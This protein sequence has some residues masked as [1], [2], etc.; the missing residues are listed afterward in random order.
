MKALSWKKL[1]VDEQPWLKTRFGDHFCQISADTTLRLSSSVKDVA[2]VI[3]NGVVPEDIELLTKL[4]MRPPQGITD[5]DFVFGYK[6]SDE[7]VKGSLESDLALQTYVLAYP[8]EWAIVQKVLGIARQK[9]RHPCA[10]VIANQPI[11]TFIPLT[12]VGG[13]QTTQYTAGSVEAAGGLKMDFLVIN[14]LG[15]IRD[16]IEKIQDRFGPDRFVETVIKSRRVPRHRLIIANGELTDIWDLPEDQAVFREVSEGKTETVFQFNTPGAVQWLVH[17]NRWKDKEAGKKAIDSIEAMSAFTALDRPGP[18]GAYVETSDGKAHNMLVEF[19]RRARGEAAVG[20]LPIFTELFPETYGVLTYQEQ[21]Q[22]AYQILTGCSGPEAEEFRTNVA[23]KKMDK[24]LKAFPGWMERVGA[25]LGEQVAKTIWDT[26]VTWGQYGFNKSH[27]ICYVHIAYACAYLKH[28]YP[29]EWWCSVLGN[30]AKNEVAQT[31]WKHCGHLVNLPDVNKSTT[32]FC[33]QGDRIQ[34]P[35]S[36]IKGVGEKAHLQ[37]LG[38]GPY[39]DI[40]DF[41]QKTEEFCVKG[42]VPAID[43]ATGLQK[44][45]KKGELSWR[46]ARSA[47]TRGVVHKL[48][49]AGVMDSLFEPGLDLAERVFAYEKALSAAK[50]DKKIQPVPPAFLVYSPVLTFLLRKSVLPIYTEPLM[51]LLLEPAAGAPLYPLSNLTGGLNKV[52]KYGKESCPVISYDRMQRLEQLDPWPTDFRAFVA[53]PVFVGE[54]RLFN[55]GPEK[56]K[57][58]CELQ[59]EMDGLPCKYVKWGDRKTFKIDAM[60]KRNLTGSIGLAIFCKYTEK[61][62]FGLED[63]II[64]HMNPAA[65]GGKGD[66]DEQDQEDEA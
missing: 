52:F 66:D 33:I 10:F 62:P 23:K 5:H 2:R 27:S 38:N 4:F 47:L 7:W 51:P 37:L 40:Q 34:A 29:L 20:G 63:V 39:T 9:T 32:K 54:R 58:A 44:V 50:G 12:V 56:A 26:F 61:K 11:D 35:V 41:C 25:K 17:F 21:L 1:E 28:H 24:V 45:T 59:L 30:A 49:A 14:S 48:I 15:D 46:K 57:E 22:K 55:W 65:R 42:K 53:I 19:A 64:F 43:K 3:H 60:Y 6:G 8:R 18:L 31:F 13:V 36:L 16:C